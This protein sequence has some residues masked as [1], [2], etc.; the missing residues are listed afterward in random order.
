MRY[1][2]RTVCQL[3]SPQTREK[4]VYSVLF[5]KYVKLHRRSVSECSGLISSRPCLWKI[6]LS[7]LFL[8]FPSLS[9]RLLLFFFFVKAIV[10]Q[11]RH[12]SHLRYMM[13]GV[14][15]MSF[16]AATAARSFSRFLFGR[17]CKKF[18]YLCHLFIPFICFV[19]EYK[20]FCVR[21]FLLLFRPFFPT[22]EAK[23]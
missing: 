23:T 5:T 20:F 16:L 21:Y 18:F 19:Q 22:S 15:A 9:F 1:Y 13:H 8:L 14:S 11:C 6:S 3:K 7:R 17:K 10:T 2:R 4:P 12:R